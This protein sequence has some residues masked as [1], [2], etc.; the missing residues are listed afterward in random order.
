MAVARSE[1]V[2][3]GTGVSR[4]AALLG[5]FNL[6]LSGSFE[7]ELR[8]ER[9]FDAG[10]TWHPLS[11]DLTGE[12]AIFRRPASLVGEEWE[13]GVLYRLNCIGHS[14]GAVVYRLSQ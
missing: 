8:L 6:T 1:G 5:A 4:P 9:S 11:R 12:P 2:F 10:A 13:R 3:T 14:A 7:A